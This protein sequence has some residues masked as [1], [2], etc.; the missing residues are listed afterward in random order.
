M[1]VIDAVCEPKTRDQLRA[2]LPDI[3]AAPKDNGRVDL[4]VVR[5][6][7]GQRQ[8]PESIRVTAAGGLEGDHWAKECWRTTDDG[9]PHPDIQVCFMPSRVIRAVAGPIENWA[10]AGDNLFVDMDLTPE[11]TPP[12]TKVAIGTV[13]LMI[14][15]EPHKGCEKFVERYGRDAVAFVNV[16]DGSRYKLRGIYGRVTKDGVITVGDTMR[17]I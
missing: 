2:A 10:A 6:G 8:L 16:G 13:E 3:L 9:Q 1:D 7:H 11:N 17:K 4:I 14:T 5:P 12:G 15:E